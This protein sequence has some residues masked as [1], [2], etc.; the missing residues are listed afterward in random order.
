[1]VTCEG[2][3]AEIDPRD[4]IYQRNVREARGAVCTTCTIGLL[5]EWRK[6]GGRTDGKSCSACGAPSGL[7]WAAR[8]RIRRLGGRQLCSTCAEREQRARTA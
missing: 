2:C 5:P 6:A 4:R 1:M 7:G 3:A 8:R